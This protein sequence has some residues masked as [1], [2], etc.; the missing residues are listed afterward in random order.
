M[1]DNYKCRL[2]SVVIVLKNDA[3]DLL[4]IGGEL[5]VVGGDGRTDVDYPMT[6]PG[7]DWAITGKP[8]TRL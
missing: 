3:G 4:L 6:R 5:V 8:R 2:P 1:T 7:I